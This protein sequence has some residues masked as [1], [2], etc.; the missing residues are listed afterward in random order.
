MPT[1]LMVVIVAVAVP[2]CMPMVMMFARVGVTTIFVIAGSV[3]SVYIRQV[4]LEFCSVGWVTN[5]AISIRGGRCLQ[6]RQLASRRT[7]VD[8]VRRLPVQWSVAI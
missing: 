3:P 1:M 2:V 5:C 8:P 4:R 7:R 6:G